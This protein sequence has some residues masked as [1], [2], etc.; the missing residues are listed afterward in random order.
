LGGYECSCQLG[1]ELHS[2]RKDCETACGG[3]IDTQNGTITSPSFPKEYPTNKECVWE[4]IAPANHKVTLNFTHFDLEGNM[5]YQPAA[6]EYDSLTVYSKLNDDSDSVK[7]HG[8]FCG[9]KIPNPITSESNILRLEFKSD[10]TIQ[11]TGFAG[12]FLTDVDEC[13]ENNGGCQHECHNTI[14]SYSKH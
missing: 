2:N 11:K 5:Y 7:K 8:V 3:I 6:C 1:Y 10:K 9:N 13:A 4:I 12:I 14:G